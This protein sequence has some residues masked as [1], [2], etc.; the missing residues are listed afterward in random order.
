MRRTGIW[1]GLL[2][3]A[4]LAFVFGVPAHAASGESTSGGSAPA[5]TGPTTK[6]T[7]GVLNVSD[8]AP[9]YLAIRDGIFARHG[10]SVETTP[11]PGAAQATS[12]LMSG[13]M[14]FAFGSYVPFILAA[15]KG[16][17]LKIAAPADDVND[18]YSRVV[19]TKDSAVNGTA[20]LKGRK[21]AVSALVN[22]GTV[23]I[24]E[25]LKAAGVDPKSVTFVTFPFPN[26]VAALEHGQVDAAWLVEPFLTQARDS[27]KTRDLFNPFAGTMQD[28]P[29]AGYM[30]TAGYAKSNPEVAVNFR[31]A[32]AEASSRAAADPTAV[33]Q[34]IPTFTKIP[35]STAA[36]IALPTYTSV[37]E[38]A[39]LQHLADV[40]AGNGLLGKAFDASVFFGD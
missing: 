40:M 16:V 4:L 22:F 1:R 34:L 2:S 26:M 13:D 37:L 20:D 10:L 21:I 17:P 31:R 30:M 28:I 33:R 23:A 27:G 19:V 32:M 12:G 15:Q 29:A 8:A 9:L 36:K 14:Q 5:A 25:A 7:V 11:A 6:V 38:P 39:K 35:E 24:Q 18:S 3:T